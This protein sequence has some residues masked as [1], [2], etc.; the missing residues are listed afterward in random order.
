MA[1]IFDRVVRISPNTLARTLAHVP[2]RG[3]RRGRVE[4]PMQ[5][6]GVSSDRPSLILT[7]VATSDDFVSGSRVDDNAIA[8]V[9][10]SSVERSLEL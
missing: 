4:A 9:S 7:A 1:P 10:V 3:S 8:V 6:L 2:R 5:C